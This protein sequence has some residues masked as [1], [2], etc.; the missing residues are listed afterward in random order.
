MYKIPYP[1]TAV[2]PIR[3][4]WRESKHWLLSLFKLM[5]AGIRERGKEGGREEKLLV[6]Q[7][8]DTVDPPSAHNYALLLLWASQANAVPVRI[9]H[10]ACLQNVQCLHAKCTTDTI[11]KHS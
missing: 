7:L 11:L 4:D 5:V 10:I 9:M 1:S 6:E 8:V 2:F 3:R